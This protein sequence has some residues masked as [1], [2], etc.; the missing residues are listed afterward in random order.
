MPTVHPDLRHLRAFLAVAAT[1]SFTRAAQQ[2]GVAQPGLSQTI[3]SLERELGTSLFVR[4][5]RS[6]QLTDAGQALAN[7]LMPAL[8]GVDRALE[9]VR[10]AAADAPVLR[11]AFKA[12][13]VGPLLSEV[14]HAFSAA[15]PTAQVALQ[16][17]E[18]GDETS[19]VRTG[20][21]DVALVRPPVDTT[22]LQTV[23]LVT[24][25][26]VVGLAAGHRLAR[27][28]AVHIDDLAAEPVVQGAGV[29]PELQAYWTVDPRP[30]GRPAILG[31][32][33]RSN[34]EMIEH[35]ALGTAVCIAAATVR[36]YYQ[37]PD[38][39]FRT[40]HGL[41]PTPLLLATAPGTPARFVSAFRAI[42]LT[43][44]QELRRPTQGRV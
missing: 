4:T 12:G 17:L 10:S 41:P 19:S 15:H 18:W 32:A 42:A 34:E 44:A 43:V 16:R 35:V 1:G 28:P 21:A 2:L 27:R 24:D 25:R 11:V 3:R 6:V 13:G 8:A 5:T 23:V 9:R 22:G 39:M 26:R 30:D 14:L 36:D 7:E 29:P 33:V 40:L 38:V 20:A 31:P 37:R